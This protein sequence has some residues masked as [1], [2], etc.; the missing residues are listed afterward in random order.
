[1]EALVHFDT[2]WIHCFWDIRIEHWIYFFF[3]FLIT[4]SVKYIDESVSGFEAR[5]DILISYKNMTHKILDHFGVVYQIHYQLDLKYRIWPKIH[6][7][8]VKQIR[9]SWWCMNFLPCN[10][11][12][13]LTFVDDI[14]VQLYVLGRTSRISGHHNVLPNLVIV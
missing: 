2:R 10:N 4:S 1:M 12:L 13:F 5:V 3:I 8:N 11:N 7:Q 14:K 9:W 6:G